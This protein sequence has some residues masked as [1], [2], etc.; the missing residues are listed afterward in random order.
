MAVS[1]TGLCGGRSFRYTEKMM[2]I[3]SV[4]PRCFI[5]GLQQATSIFHTSVNK[6]ALFYA[7]IETVRE[8]VH[9]R[10]SQLIRKVAKQHEPRHKSC[11]LLDN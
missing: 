4:L 11:T 6:P 5:R 7:I 8:S 9:K 3:S 10:E 2:L 1:D